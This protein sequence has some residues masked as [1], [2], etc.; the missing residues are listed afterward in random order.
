MTTEMVTVGDTQFRRVELIPVHQKDKL[1]YVAKLPARFV[2]DTYTVE[3][4]Q[5]D[6]N[7]ETAFAATFPDDTEYFKHMLDPNSRRQQPKE[8][9]RKLDNTRVMKIRKFINEREYALF[10]NSIIVTCELI[11]ELRGI[12]P[13]AKFDDIKDELDPAS[14]GL[15]FLEESGPS[16]QPCLYIPHRPNSILV[17]DGQHRLK[18]L[19]VADPAVVDD[20]EL[21][22]SFILGFSRSA[23]A[24]LFYTINYEQKSVNKSLL[25]HLSGEFSRELNEIMFMHETVR[26]LNEIDYS[27][28]HK[29][30]KM[31][32]TVDRKSP[33]EDRIKM[34]ISQAF[35]IDY[36]KGTISEKTKTSMYP[37][38]FLHYYRHENLRIEIARFLLKYFSAVR[39]LRKED[40]E[41]P[42]GSMI[43]NTL[44]IGAFVR[45]LH[46][47]FVKIFVEELK[48]DP[49][50]IA[51]IT[52][53]D[54]VSKLSGIENVDFSKAGEFGG[55]ASVGSLNKLKERLVEN[56]SYFDTPS[57]KDF[58][59]QYKSQ[60]LRPY[61]QWLESQRYR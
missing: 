53:E 58:L 23:I 24:E 28:F 17:I 30:I 4:A 36:L 29:R 10:P 5:Y 11:N 16:G 56:I 40:W 26:I 22:L 55:V 46:F 33:P 61:V 15:G 48:S 2:L 50:R 14:K 41:N 7:K 49:A 12:S 6:V 38:I 47:L 44:G 21:V 51:K 13:E 52:T 25:Y 39:N 35:L 37:P 19:E 20:Y 54:L 8:F 57:Y 34:T 27:P 9:E 42:G 3:P 43:C 59:V 32:G 1:F 60:Y 18:G 45:V 31:L